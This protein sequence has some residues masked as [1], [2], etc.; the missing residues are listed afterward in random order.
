MFQRVAIVVVYGFRGGCFFEVLELQG[1]SS[2]K[3]FGLGLGNIMCYKYY[4]SLCRFN[5]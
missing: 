3:T 5:I 1:L 4:K 2:I